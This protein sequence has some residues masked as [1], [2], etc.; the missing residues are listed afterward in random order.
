MSQIKN[1]NKTAAKLVRISLMG[2]FVIF[3]Q[4]CRSGSQKNPGDLP[5]CNP[6]LKVRASLA[7]P[8]DENKVQ[9]DENQL[10]NKKKTPRLI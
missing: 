5:I 6:H 7:S 4:N 3:L 2:F 9:L 8:F 10:K 1:F